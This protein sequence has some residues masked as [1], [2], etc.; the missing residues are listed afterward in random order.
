SGTPVRA[1]SAGRSGD[2]PGA[3]P[4]ER[5]SSRCE[6]PS[7]GIAAQVQIAFTL[8]SESF[9]APVKYQAAVRLKQ[10]V[11]NNPALPVPLHDLEGDIFLDNSQIVVRELQAANRESRLYVDGRM[12]R[13]PLP[14]A[15]SFTVKAVNLSFG[16]DIHQHL[17]PTLLR[18]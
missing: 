1:A 3:V 18:L 10:G 11:I 16:R 14:P 17:P 15:K 2:V 4:G 7:L 5:S 9:T 8:D 6:I 12:S 13:D